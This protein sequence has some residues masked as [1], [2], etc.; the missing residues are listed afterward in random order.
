MGQALEALGLIMQAG[1]SMLSGEEG[2]N[3][4]LKRNVETLIGA[5]EEDQRLQRHVEAD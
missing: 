5:Y 1:G 2:E 4:K 3:Q